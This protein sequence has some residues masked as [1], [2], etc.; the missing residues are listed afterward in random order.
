MIKIKQFNF[1]TA[2][3]LFNGGRT[4]RTP[5]SH[6]LWKNIFWFFDDR[7]PGT[8]QSQTNAKYACLDHF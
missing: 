8:K 5:Q 2:A 4:V 1:R 6:K 7:T 3:K